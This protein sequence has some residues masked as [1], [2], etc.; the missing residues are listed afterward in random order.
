[1][2]APDPPDWTQ[3]SCFALF[4]TISLLHE[5]QCKMD[6]TGGINAQVRATKSRRNFSQRMHPIHPIGRQTHILGRF[7]SFRYCKNFGPKWAE[8]VPLMHKF[9]QRSR[10]AIFRNERPWSTHWTPNSYFG[11]FHTGSLRHELRCKMGCTGATN[12][13]VRATRLCRNFLQGAPLIH[14]VELQTHVLGHLGLFCYC[15][16]FGAKQAKLLQLTH[17]FVERSHVRIFRNERI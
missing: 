6:R 11:L 16:N 8:L 12:A 5:L 7:G 14:P 15:T 2:N 1:M 13:Q 10:V 17:R 9:M 3:N 4:Q